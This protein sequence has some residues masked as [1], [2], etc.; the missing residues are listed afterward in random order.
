MSSTYQ[1]GY[2]FSQLKAFLKNTLG[3]K[4]AKNLEAEMNKI[5]LILSPKNRG[6]GYDLCYQRYTVELYIE[7]LPF[8]A[9]SPATLLANVSAWLVEHDSERF[10]NNDLEDPVI[11]VILGDD[12]S[13]EVLIELELE[14]PIKIKPDEKGSVYWNG[15]RWS[16][17]QYDIWHAENL[18]D[19]SVSIK[20]N[21]L[22]AAND[23][24]N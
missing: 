15:Q 22:D 11:E 2:K 24:G 1:A 8:K 23:A 19:V 21:E 20:P 9:Y 6:Q 7:R 10:D 3:P 13:A 12:D 5:Q 4:L 18:V 14:E 17:E 16:V